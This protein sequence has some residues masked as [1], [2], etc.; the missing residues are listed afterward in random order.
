MPKYKLTRGSIGLI[1]DD[2]ENIDIKRGDIVELT[3]ERAKDFKYL[4]RTEDGGSSDGDVGSGKKEVIE[5]P[6]P[7]KQPVENVTRDWSNTQDMKASDVIDLIDE[8]DSET[9]LIN[10]REVEQK[11]QNRIGV[12]NAIKKK[13][14][15]ID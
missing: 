7:E 11:G 10:L 5:K 12:M 14:S 4:K 3:E 15:Q 1:T 6:P 13:L 2:G 8:T 9:D